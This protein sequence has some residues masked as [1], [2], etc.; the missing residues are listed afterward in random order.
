M[1]PYKITLACRN[2]DRTEAIIRGLVKPSGVDLEVNQV[3]Q[4]R[5]L[6]TRMFNGEFDVSE[7]S[8]AEYVYYTS[9]DNSEFIAIPV[10]PSKV[11]RHSFIFFNTSAKIEK[12]EDL[13]EKRIGFIEWVQTAAIWIRGTLVEEYHVSPENTGWYTP[14]L[15]HWDTGGSKDEVK[16][17]DGTEIRW[18][19]NNGKD[20]IEML[21]SAL[22][23][24]KLDALGTTGLPNSYIKGDKTIKRLFENYRD[25]EMSYFKKTRIFPIMHILVARKSVVEQHPDLPQKLF[26]L[27]VESKRLAQEKLKKDLSL[28]LVWKN[29]YLEE[30]EKIFQGDP[31]A[32]GLNR[33]SHIIDKFLTYCY[34][35]GV[36]A[37][38][39]NAR[40]LFVPDTWDLTEESIPTHS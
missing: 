3:D 8:L 10:F 35:Q 7:F 28:S 26:E 13:T 15:H 5:I 19:E 25:E 23:E 1:E 31:W 30:E 2:Y 37:R 6:F 24:G 18:L 16:P 4:P 32:Y 33:N 14:Q 20:R 39:M 29:P 22:V 40:D 9:R 11:F 12:P 21:D 34:N 36:S 17:R 38:K 27:F